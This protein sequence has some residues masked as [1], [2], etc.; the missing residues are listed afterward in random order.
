[1]QVNQMDSQLKT[2]KVRSNEPCCAAVRSSN[3]PK[4]EDGSLKMKA[5]YSYLPS[6]KYRDEMLKYSDL[7]V[8]FGK[9]KYNAFFNRF[10]EDRL[11]RGAHDGDSRLRF[12]QARLKIVWGPDTKEDELNAYRIM[13]L[14]MLVRYSLMRHDSCED[15][16]A[17]A[18]VITDIHGQF[19]DLLEWLYR[20]GGPEHCDTNLV[21]CGD[22]VD[23]GPQQLETVCLFLYYKLRYP[24]RVFILRGNHEDFELHET[25]GFYAEIEERFHENAVNA[26]HRRL[27]HGLWRM[28]IHV[29]DYLPVACVLEQRILC[30]HGGLSPALSACRTCQ[31]QCERCPLGTVCQRHKAQLAP[32]ALTSYLNWKVRR[33]VQVGSSGFVSSSRE[34]QRS[35]SLLNHSAYDFVLSDL[36]WSDPMHHGMPYMSPNDANWTSLRGWH[37]NSE[38][39]IAYTFGFDAIEKTMQQFNLACLIRGHETKPAGY[40]WHY[41]KRCVTVFSA[42]NYT[43]G[44]AATVALVTE[45]C[46]GIRKRNLRIDLVMFPT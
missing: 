20:I 22:M 37:F 13:V 2:P 18:Y 23:R 11:L 44:N 9:L 1:M 30:L 29:F 39:Q 35:L 7:S 36:L 31:R 41:L 16:P 25:Y 33:P 12:S 42:P 3:L 15:L 4:N 38:R 26:G 45:R 6:G 17:P 28:F 24:S 19:S 32:G 5:F 8:L 43:G 40:E 21:C 27:A 46:N 14:L 34:T 10:A